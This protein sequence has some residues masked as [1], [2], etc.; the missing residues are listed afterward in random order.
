MDNDQI[1]D[2]Q[3]E[4]E[5]GILITAAAKRQLSKAVGTAIGLAVVMGLSLVYS[6]IST[7][8]QIFTYWIIGSARSVPAFYKLMPFFYFIVLAFQ[9][10]VFVKLLN[11]IGKSR[12][13]TTTNFPLAGEQT[14]ATL[15]SLFI[16]M[17]ISTGVTLLNMI[18]FWIVPKF[19]SLH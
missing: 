5:E 17:A 3:T 1:L 14:F 13:L 6:L 2:Q 4:N 12:K 18:M 9:A 15:N 7:L 8:S 11:F 19:M 16:W 10:V